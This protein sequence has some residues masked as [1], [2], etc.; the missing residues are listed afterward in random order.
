M[1]AEQRDEQRVAAGLAGQPVAGV[2]QDHGD[3]GGRGAGGHVAG[4]LLVAGRVGDDEG[5]PV[6]GEEA[7]GDVDGDA[8]LALGLEPVDQQREIDLAALRAVLAR[9]ALKRRHLIVEDLLGVVQEPPDQGGLAVIDRAAGD[10]AQHF[11]RLVRAQEGVV[12]ERFR[13]LMDR[14]QK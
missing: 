9:V 4:V 2:D 8:L 14:H 11:L 12:A 3:V 5:A 13:R 10:E 6:G 1:D 7:V